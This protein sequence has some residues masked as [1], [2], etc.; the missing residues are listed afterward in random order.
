VHDRG[1]PC[2]RR[3]A[4]RVET[5]RRLLTVFFVF[6]CLRVITYAPQSTHESSEPRFFAAALST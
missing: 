4:P 6:S 5:D 2:G 3:F 1:W